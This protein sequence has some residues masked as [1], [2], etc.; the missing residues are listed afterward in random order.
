MYTGKDVLYIDVDPNN[1]V[2]EQSSVSVSIKEKQSPITFRL[3]QNQLTEDIIL[4][5]VDK[6]YSDKNI[7]ISNISGQTVYTG[8]TSDS[9]F[10]I[11]TSFLPKGIYIITAMN[12]EHSFV[13]RFVK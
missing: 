2:M 4:Y 13:K 1:W 12:N 3:G 10:K 9:E 6:K 5:F 11:N 7:L 8:Q